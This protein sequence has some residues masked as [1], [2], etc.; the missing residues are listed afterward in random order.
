MKKAWVENGKIR[1]IA[2]DEPYNIY[3]PD[4][5]Q[6]YDTLVPVDAQN[7]WEKNEKGEWVAPAQSEIIQIVQPRII[8]DFDV[9]TCLTFGE[10]VK[11]DNDLEPEIKSAKLELMRHNMTRP[12]AQEIIDWL[13]NKGILLQ[14]SG[15]KVLE[16]Y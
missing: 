1:D 3:H 10:K 16:L 9:R 7:G 11:W 13:V 5:A 15:V 6:Y 12:E 8:T 14:D 2:H 4:V